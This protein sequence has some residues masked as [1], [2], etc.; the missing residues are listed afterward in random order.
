MRLFLAGLILAA[1]G[2]SAAHAASF[3]TKL[4]P[5]GSDIAGTKRMCVANDGSHRV[6]HYTST[7]GGACAF[8]PDAFGASYWYVPGVIPA[9]TGTIKVV[10]A[11]ANE[12]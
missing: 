9:F 2:A 6:S 1:A 8:S 7:G 11:S 3:A 5:N 12:Y 10:A 4:H